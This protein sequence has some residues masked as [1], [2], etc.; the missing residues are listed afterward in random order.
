M[1]AHYAGYLP[2]SLPTCLTNYLTSEIFDSSDGYD[3]SES[4]ENNEKKGQGNKCQTIWVVEFS[5]FMTN[6]VISRTNF[7]P[8]PAIKRSHQNVSSNCLIKMSHQMFDQNVSSK[9]LIKISHQ[10]VSSKCLIKM[11]NKKA[12]SKGCIKMFYQNVS[13]KGLIKISHW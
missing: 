12:S 9:C 4:N 11:S 6:L 1:H 7:Q 2:T 3:S 8:C 10:N 5:N 13:S